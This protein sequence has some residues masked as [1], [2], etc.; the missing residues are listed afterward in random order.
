MK[1]QQKKAAITAYKERKV[2]P[3]I[4]AIRCTADGRRW[5][6]AAPDLSTIQNRHWFG[7]RMG[8]HPHPQMQSAWRAYGLQS[9]AFEEIERFEDL[10]DDVTTY[11][12]DSKL[13]DR[14]AH[15]RTVLGAE[16]I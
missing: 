1:P 8:T 4:Y 10:D 16:A 7:L 14:L 11:V 13:H 5:I 12:R 3:G 9:F 2:V 6:G 15:W